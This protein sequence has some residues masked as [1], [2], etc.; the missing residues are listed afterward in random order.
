MANKWRW[1]E[2]TRVNEVDEVDKG[3]WSWG[4]NDVDVK[5]LE[6]I[7]LIKVNKVEE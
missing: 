7:R 5:W 4:M 3:C 6:L 1:C 2:M